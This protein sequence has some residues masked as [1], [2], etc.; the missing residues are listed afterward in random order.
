MEGDAANY[1]GRLKIIHF[2]VTT[3]PQL[4]TAKPKIQSKMS[5]RNCEASQQEIAPEN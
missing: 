3:R 5:L 1:G 2:A 4:A